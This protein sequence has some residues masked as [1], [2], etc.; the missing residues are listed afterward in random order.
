MILAISRQINENKFYIVPRPVNSDS[1]A[2][3]ISNDE[4]WI[5]IIRTHCDSFTCLFHK[6]LQFVCIMCICFNVFTMNWV[7]SR[8]SFYFQ[9]S[10]LWASFGFEM[11]LFQCGFSTLKLICW[12]LTWNAGSKY[13][14]TYTRQ[15]LPSPSCIALFVMYNLKFKRAMQTRATTTKHIEQWAPCAVK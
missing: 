13:S 5:I 2:K 3:L 8:L 12:M 10:V 6:L 14:H 7:H 4:R 9:F 15:S 1:P 11:L